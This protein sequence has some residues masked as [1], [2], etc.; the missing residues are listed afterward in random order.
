MRHTLPMLKESDTR[1][2]QTAPA[3]AQALAHELRASISGEVRFDAGSRALY[4]T[5][6]S[7]YRQVPVGVVIPTNAEDVIQT[8]ALCRR[9][10][11]P[12]LPRGGGTSL[13]GQCCKIAV[14]LDLSK[15]MHSVLEIDPHK[16]LA[17]VQ[18]GTI[19]DHLRNA[20]EHY[21]LTFGPDPATHSQ[22]TLGGMIGNNSC[23]V[24]SVMA[25]MTSDNIEELEI[26]TY[27][28]LRMHVGKTSDEELERI[29][30]EGG[31]RGE[32]YARL[33][34]L[35]DKYADLIR[36]RYPN[37]PRR[38]SGYSLDQL[39]PE[40]GFHVARAL[41]GTEGTC[42]TVLAA[43]VRLVDSPPARTLLVLGFSDAFEAADHVP[44]IMNHQPIALE[45][46]DLTL[47]ENMRKKN[48][49]LAE[50]ALLPEGGG[51]LLVEF[52]GENQQVAHS[53]ARALMEELRR[54]R[55]VPSMEL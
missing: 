17:R 50:I 43:T 48:L 19:L 12:L 44:E 39:L 46:L 10:H 34:T 14:V 45:G 22:C 52:G 25:G 11:V 38:V 35:R 32:N 23:G 13:A 37:I 31:R 29:I 53:R 9:Y 27:D 49:N 54:A 26:L 20:A 21:H 55:N 41:V 24:H 1:R 30:S 8:V 47:I 4:A 33:K 15:Y 6:G 40:N 42:V 51:W 28:G 3:D 2:T 7:N 5:D 16:K 36:T 18:P